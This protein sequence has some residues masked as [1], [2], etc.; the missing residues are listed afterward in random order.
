MLQDHNKELSD[1]LFSE[2]NPIPIKEA[3]YQKGLISS[4]T[5]RLPL[6]KMEND[7]KQTLI[8]VMKKQGFLK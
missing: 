5:L 4:N 3:C 1:C 2:V 7:N 8:K 6:T